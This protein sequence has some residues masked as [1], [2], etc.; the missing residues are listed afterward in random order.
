MTEMGITS[1]F[2]KRINIAKYKHLSFSGKISKKELIIRKV[3]SRKAE[4]RKVNSFL[5]PFS[6]LKA[7]QGA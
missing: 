2:R 7:L 1:R 4:D 3:C 6:T 5:A